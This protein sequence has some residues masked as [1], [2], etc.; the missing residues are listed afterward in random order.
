MFA[1]VVVG[2]AAFARTRSSALL[3]VAAVVALTA[4]GPCATL[5]GFLR[6]AEPWASGMLWVSALMSLALLAV[7]VISRATP[8]VLTLEPKDVRQLGDFCR[9]WVL[10]H[11][12]PD[13]LTG[14]VDRLKA[15][16]TSL[17]DPSEVALSDLPP[18]RD[19]LAAAQ[20][21]VL[22]ACANLS[23]ADAS[24]IEASSATGAPLSKLGKAIQ[25]LRAL[26]PGRAR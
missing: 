6:P 23:D 10:A 3:F 17:L 11:M 21:A 18:W 19:P 8:W 26:S 15:L 13:E 9:N 5:L 12:T 22:V 25:A 14:E 7:G 24:H 16:A 2:F 4:V 20:N 1:P